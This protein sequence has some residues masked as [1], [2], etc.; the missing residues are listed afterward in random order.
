MGQFA[1]SISKEE[2]QKLPYASFDGDIIVVSRFDMVQ[3]AVDYLNT[4]KVLGV[5]T[6]TKPVFVKGKSNQVALLQVSSE[7]RCYLFRLNLLNIPESVAELFAN[8][9]ITK[10][11]LSLHDDFRQLRKRMPSFKC[12]NYVELQSYV[13]KFGI[14]D[15]SLQKIYAII[16]NLQISKRQQ[17]SNW[18]ANPLEPAQVRYAALDAYATLMIYKTLSSSEEGKMNPADHLSSSVLE[19][20]Q[21]DQMQRAKERRERREKKKQEMQQKPKVEVQKTPEQIHEDNM[22][23]IC[24]LYKKFQGHRTKSIIPIAQAGSGRQYFLVD[25]DSGKYVA[26]IGETVEENNAFIYIAKQLKRA[27]ASVPKVYHVSKDRMIYLQTYCGDNSLYKVLEVFREKNEYSKTSI[28]LLCKAMDD[29]AKMQFVGAKT[30]DFAKCYPE[31]EFSRDGLMA[32]FAKFETY[33]VKKHPIA[34]EEARLHDDF[35]KMWT[36]MSEVRKDAWGFMYR[37][38]QSRN[39]MVKAGSLW[40]IDFQG[41][42]KGPIWYDLVSFVYQV[43]ARYPE[44]VKKMMITAYLKAVKKYISINDEEFY[45]YLSFFI[46][47]RM[48]QVLG[49]Y[50]LRGLEEKKETFLG[51][52]PDTLKTL[53]GVV[54]K[55]E[56]EYPELVKV[57]KEATKH[58]GE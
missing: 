14:T 49:T 34:Y 17:T 23:A 45:G 53:N 46:L 9:N 25:G 8:P 42:R 41:G 2:I 5:D 28:R 18:E 40:Y 47:T 48:V 6:E 36:A 30:V 20:I 32:D 15:K 35:E 50:G 31:P 4:Q 26:T 33:F 43:R 52:I 11:G 1:E 12:E 7:T 37:D 55:F 54:D 44:H 57:I 39:V 21:Q 56:T 58:Y 10:I 24:R 3:E 22:Q 16:F 51:Q 13:E 29:L 27:G 38:F 19:K